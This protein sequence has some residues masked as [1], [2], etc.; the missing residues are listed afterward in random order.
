MCQLCNAISTLLSHIVV[1]ILVVFSSYSSSLVTYSS[2]SKY[3]CDAVSMIRQKKNLSYFRLIYWFLIIYCILN[4]ATS[5]STWLK[6]VTNII[7]SLFSV[8]TDNIKVVYFFFS[9]SRILNRNFFYEFYSFNYDMII[10]IIVHLYN[11][12]RDES[13]YWVEIDFSL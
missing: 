8:D 6:F 3:K 9:S 5:L 11:W 1:C 4:M 2:A 12:N 10:K 13:K 7:C